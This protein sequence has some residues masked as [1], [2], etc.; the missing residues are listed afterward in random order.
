MEKVGKIYNHVNR[1]IRYVGFEFGVG[2]IQPRSSEL[3]YHTRMGDCKDISLVLVAMLKEA[4]L[5][6]RLALLRVRDSGVANLAVPFL[7]EFNHAICYVN[8]GGGF[9]I[10]GTAKMG[11][12]MEFPGQDSGVTA[13]VIDESGYSFINTDSGV[14]LKNLESERTD[15]AIDEKGQAALSRTITKNGNLADSLR[16]ASMDREGWMQR[17]REYWNKM[18]PGSR[19]NDL[20][21]ISTG[22]DA[23]VSYS[24]NIDIPSFVNVDGDEVILR[25]FLQ[26]SD[27]YKKYAML[28]SRKY[29]IILSQKYKV[30]ARIRYQVPGDFEI[31]KIPED[32]SFK[33][34]KFSADFKFSKSSDGRYIEVESIIQ[35]KDCRIEVSEYGEFRDFTRLIEKKE[36]EKIILVRSGKK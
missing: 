17:I 30:E 27:Y 3:T 32:E 31:F 6:A 26:T 19:I 22:F 25:S 16:S 5:D 2:G 10:D 35:F 23:P 1:L 14:Y 7:G 36:N 28:K 9:F 33:N 15:A 18:F 13:F 24:Y 34:K 12:F 20:R 21:L 4:G 8:A 29:P 11:G